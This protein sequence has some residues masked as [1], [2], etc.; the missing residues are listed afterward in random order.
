MPQ[1]AVIKITLVILV[2][3]I[4]IVLVFQNVYLARNEANN[5]DTKQ[6]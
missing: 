1:L 3:Q 6:L 2:F 4:S 5:K